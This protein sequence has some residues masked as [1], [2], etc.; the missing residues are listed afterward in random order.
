MVLEPLSKKELEDIFDKTAQ[1]VIR[2]F[3]DKMI[4]MQPELHCD[5]KELPIQ[6]PKEHIEQWLVQALDVDSVGAGSNSIDILKK[7]EFGADVKMLSCAIDKNGNL[8][9][10]KLSGETSLAQKFK[11]AGSNL[12]TLFKNADYDIIVDEWK[13]ILKNKYSNVQEDIKNIY[14]FILLRANK[15]FYLSG[16]KL[17]LNKLD[18]IEANINKSNGNNAVVD[19][20]IDDEYGNIRIYKAKKRMELRLK[21]S[22]WVEEDKVIKFEFNTMI[23]RANLR[24]IVK[25]NKLN[26]H[27]KQIYREVTHNGKF[28]FFNWK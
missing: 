7:G 23:P 6:I 4:Y 12:D 22:K 26:K 27:K 15:T 18:N 10:N 28:K 20:M 16:I 19:K 9:K 3:L 25:N 5:Q 21:T 2:Y 14:Y 8:D 24:D 13:E 11:G 1:D 17:N